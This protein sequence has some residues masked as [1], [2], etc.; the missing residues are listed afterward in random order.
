MTDPAHC[1][2]WG[3][4]GAAYHCSGLVAGRSW[5]RKAGWSKVGRCSDSGSGV[6]R[7][8]GWGCA[9][10]TG[11]RGLRGPTKT[12][13]QRAS[14]HRAS[15]ARAVSAR[16]RPLHPLIPAA[17]Q[18]ACGKQR[19]PAARFPHPTPQP[20]TQ[21]TR[22]HHCSHQASTPT[23]NTHAPS[24]DREALQRGHAEWR[25]ATTTRPRGGLMLPPMPR[26]GPR[27]NHT[28]RM[29]GARGLPLRRGSRSA[30]FW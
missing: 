24:T 22:R 30:C 17:P 3:R 4:R 23:E 5:P 8:S 2:T 26:P 9:A 1:G 28:P 29:A 11:A 10:T 14:G 21:P 15:H 6:R 13:S 27:S 12:I 7:V 19:G 20:P 18:S 25:L 16:A